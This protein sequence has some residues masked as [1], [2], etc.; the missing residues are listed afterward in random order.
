MRLGECDVI[1]RCSIVEILQEL[2]IL[3]KSQ[4]YTV[5]N[6]PARQHGK[7]PMANINR[8]HRL[9]AAAKGWFKCQSVA[10]TKQF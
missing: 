10:L 8:K 6:L 3:S 1:A 7:H 4:S 5:L 9:A 2:Q